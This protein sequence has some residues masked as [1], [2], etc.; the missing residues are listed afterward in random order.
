M[1]GDAIDR[2]IERRTDGGT[3]RTFIAIDLPTPILPA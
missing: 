3:L 2:G 1:S